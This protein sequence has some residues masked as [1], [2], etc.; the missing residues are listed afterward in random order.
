MG[1][2]GVVAFTDYGSVRDER[3]MVL[4]DPRPTAN[5]I[6]GRAERKEQWMH[7]KYSRCKRCDGTQE[8]RLYCDPK[9]LLR[10]AS[11]L[12]NRSRRE[13]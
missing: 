9:Q 13:E 6:R 12:Y 8:W 5:S 2:G 1:G 4:S 10:K 7:D 11:S 3:G